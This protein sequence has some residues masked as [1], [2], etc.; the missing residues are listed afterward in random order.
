MQGQKYGDQPVVLV[1]HEQ[2]WT[3]PQL[4]LKLGVTHK[5]LYAAARG[6]TTPS[7]LLREQLP[8]VLGTPLAELFT[9][10]SLADEPQAKGPGNRKAVSR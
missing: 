8:E 5:H 3:Y 7:W 9:P 10:E 2:R 6:V 4:A 1:M